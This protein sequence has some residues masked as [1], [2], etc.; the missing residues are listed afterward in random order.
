M[1]FEAQELRM[2]RYLKEQYCS[3]RARL[4]YM[5]YRV[6]FLPP[7]DFQPQL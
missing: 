5:A 2:R 6:S 3:Q 7:M 1:V 4:V